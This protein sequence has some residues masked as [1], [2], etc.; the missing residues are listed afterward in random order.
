MKLFWL[1]FLGLFLTFF[2]SCEKEAKNI[3]V[4]P[5][6]PKIV[7]QSFISPQDT[8]IIARVSNS[9][10]VFGKYNEGIIHDA[11]VI[12]SDGITSVQMEMKE[13]NGDNMLDYTVD[14]VLLPITPGKTYF[15][16]VTTK[17]G[18]VAEAHCTVPEVPTIEN[19]KID[20]VEVEN[21]HEY[22]IDQFKIFN[23]SFNFND[24]QSSNNYYRLDINTTTTDSS[25]I[26]GTLYKYSNQL[27]FDEVLKIDKNENGLIKISDIEVVKKNLN[28]SFI[29]L[30]PVELKLALL[31]TDIHYYEYFKTIE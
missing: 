25:A 2:S 16:K 14:P 7:I 31:N 17:D 5:I 30:R 18:R 21:I 9:I 1:L 6:A 19:L 24:L 28:S 3:N 26:D 13:I 20:S 4:P 11:E 27:Y 15:I 12:F 22:G 29:L 23:V 10:P 8:L